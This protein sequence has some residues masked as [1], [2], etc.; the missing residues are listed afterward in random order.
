MAVCYRFAG[1]RPARH[2]AKFASNCIT[3]ITAMG[4]I[5]NRPSTMLW[6]LFRLSLLDIGLA[7]NQ[8]IIDGVSN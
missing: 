4:P 2:G 8:D 5:P 3:A 1:S 6:Q 7:G